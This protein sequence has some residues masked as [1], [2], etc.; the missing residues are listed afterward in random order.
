M[1]SLNHRKFRIY[2]SRT[3]PWGVTIPGELQ[4]AYFDGFED[5]K[6]FVWFMLEAKRRRYK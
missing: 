3:A 2:A 6:I 4:P 5:A 1:K